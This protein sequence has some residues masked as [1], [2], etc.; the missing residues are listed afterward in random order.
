MLLFAAATVVTG[1]LLLGLGAARRGHVLRFVPFVP[2]SGR[3]IDTAQGRARRR[4]Q[5]A[6]SPCPVRSPR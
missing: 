2:A 5:T 4:A 3:G 1:A 6:L